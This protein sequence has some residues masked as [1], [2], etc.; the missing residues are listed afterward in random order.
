MN[1]LSAIEPEIYIIALLFGL[2][3][4][5]FCNVA[6]VENRRITAS[7]RCP[8]CGG[9]LPWYC[10]VPVFSWLALRGKCKFCREKISV[11]YPLVEAATAL[12]YAFITAVTLRLNDTKISP[13]VISDGGFF[14]FDAESGIGIGVIA[15]R[16][17]LFSALLVTAIIDAR[18]GVISPKANIFIGVL[19]AAYAALLAANAALY[20]AASDARTAVLSVAAVHL[21]GAVAVSV[22]LL[23]L[24]FL[25]DGRGIG[26]GD[27]KLMAAA[28]LFLGWRSAL[29]AF[30]LACVCGSV[31]HLT[32]MKFFGAEKKLALG[33]YLALGIF[34]AALFGDNIIKWYFGL[35]V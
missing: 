26:G 6:V 1:P 7:S 28:G 17:M 16:C 32:R 14:V 25:T 24:W 8:K 4:G 30:A 29:L 13:P 20:A 18:R 31:I 11:Q 9:V 2:A 27:I 3:A 12:A 34:T 21:Y 10:L 19:G 5:S 22:P 35:F 15:C 33:P 23:A